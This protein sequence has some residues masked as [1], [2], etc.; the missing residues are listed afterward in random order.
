M[1]ASPWS[2]LVTMLLAT[3]LGLY[4][5]SFGLFHLMIFKVNRRLSGVEKIPHSLYWGK[6]NKLRNSYRTHYPGSP[7]YS[8][9]VTL[10][11]AGL[12]FAAAAACVLWWQYAAGR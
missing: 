11:V 12:A 9:V 8:V 2:P 5:V 6:W 7:L 4:L 1:S 10:T 3:W